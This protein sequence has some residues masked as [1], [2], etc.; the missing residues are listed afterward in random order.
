MMH[1]H[2]NCVVEDAI[3]AGQG[4]CL[5]VALVAPE[6]PEAELARAGMRGVRFNF[7]RH[8]A[9]SANPQ[10]AMALTPRLAAHGLQVHFEPALLH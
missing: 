8:L 7:M 6:V 3:A 2:D 4:H 10:A 9:G 5:G 1:G